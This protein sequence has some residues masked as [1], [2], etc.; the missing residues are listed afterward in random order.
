MW[1]LLAR[2]MVLAVR[3][4]DGEVGF[5]A[6]ELARCCDVAGARGWIT[7]RARL[8]HLRVLLGDDAALADL[9]DGAAALQG[10]TPAGWRGLAEGLFARRGE[11]AARDSGAVPGDHWGSHGHGALVFLNRYVEAALSPDQGWVQLLA[12][13]EGEGLAAGH[14]PAAGGAHAPGAGSDGLG[15]DTAGAGTT[16]PLLTRR[17]MGIA[18]LVAA[19]R[20]NSEISA[21][22]QLSTRTVEG[23]V[24]R[25]FGKLGI[26]RREEL[27]VE[28]LA[29]R[30]ASHT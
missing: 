16:R 19:G 18:R 1:A 26:R 5:P 27:T 8:L 13:L 28:Y 10:P 30:V 20:R 22:L 21:D 25:I 11:T 9:V 7:V 4:Q 3:H 24:Y 29:A 15:A 17:E 23:H 2:G 12:V 14:G 6:E